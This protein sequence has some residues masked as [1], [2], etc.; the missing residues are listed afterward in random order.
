MFKNQPIYFICTILSC[1]LFG[2]GLIILIPWYLKTKATK[3]EITENDIVFEQGLLSKTRSELGLHNIRTVKVHQSF[4]NR[5]FGTGSI[6][7]Y[8]A[9][10]KPEI[11]ASGLPEPHKIRDIVKNKQSKQ[12]A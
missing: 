9:G 1:L 10:D 2:L 7:I 5:M 4:F 11:E 12:A 6:A 3:L 8:T